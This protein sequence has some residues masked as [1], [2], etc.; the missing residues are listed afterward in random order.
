[1]FCP[2]CGMQVP[3]ESSFCLKCGQSMSVPP[4]V[5]AAKSSGGASSGSR[6]WLLQKLLVGLAALVVLGGGLFLYLNRNFRQ[7]RRRH[8]T[9]AQLRILEQSQPRIVVSPRSKSPA[10]RLRTRPS[11]KAALFLIEPFL[12]ML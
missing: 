9:S 2:S 11:R 8:R 4:N 1:M 3:D 7:V 10:P 6:P 12:R 5:A